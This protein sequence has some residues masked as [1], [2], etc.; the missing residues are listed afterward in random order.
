M[1]DRGHTTHDPEPP[2]SWQPDC[3]D[4]VQYRGQVQELI[5]AATTVILAVRDAGE[6]IDPKTNAALKVLEATKE[7]ALDWLKDEESE[8][9]EAAKPALEKWR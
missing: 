4:C 7:E 6:V 3:P 8:A 9:I 2:E 1:L 5:S